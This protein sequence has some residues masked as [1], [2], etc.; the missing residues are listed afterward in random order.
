MAE[1][2]KII[3]YTKFLEK[4][5]EV[6]AYTPNVDI[7]AYS[8]NPEAS[9]SSLINISAP[10]L[11][12]CCVNGKC[13]DDYTQ[14]QCEELNGKFSINWE[15]TDSPLPSWKQIQ[16]KCPRAG[17]HNFICGEETQS[18]GTKTWYRALNCEGDG[19]T[20]TLLYT[21]DSAI[22]DAIE[23]IP[24]SDRFMLKADRGILTNS[25]N[26]L[27]QPEAKI[28]N[29]YFRNPVKVTDP[30][31]ESSS[32]FKIVQV[33]TQDI[34]ASCAALPLH[35]CC[36]ES[37]GS[38]SNSETFSKE[39]CEGRGGFWHEGENCM[40]SY[41]SQF[42]A[43]SGGFRPKW[44]GKAKPKWFPRS[45]PWPPDYF[46]PPSP[47]KKSYNPKIITPPGQLLSWPLKMNGED[48]GVESSPPMLFWTSFDASGEDYASS[49]HPDWPNG[50]PRPMREGKVNYCAHFSPYMMG[51]GG[52]N[53]YGNASPFH[54]H[55]PMSYG[56][57]YPLALDKFHMQGTSWG[58]E[59][60]KQDE[61]VLPLQFPLNSALNLPD[62]DVVAAAD[63]KVVY[64]HDG[65][66][67]RCNGNNYNVAGQCGDPTLY[68]NYIIID[69]GVKA[70]HVPE[71]GKD[72]GRVFRYTLYAHLKKDSIKRVDSI[73]FSSPWPAWK[74]GDKV[75]RGDKIGKIG[76]SGRSTYP[77]LHFEVGLELT[78]S[79]PGYEHSSG[80]KPYTTQKYLTNH[81]DPF[82][83]AEAWPKQGTADAGGNL[84][85]SMAYAD[86]VFGKINTVGYWAQQGFVM[87]ADLDYDFDSVPEDRCSL[88]YNQCS[89][90]QGPL[91]D[92]FF[93]PR[94]YWPYFMVDEDEDGVQEDL[95]GTI[96]TFTNSINDEEAYLN[97]HMEIIYPTESVGETQG[98]F[99]GSNPHWTDSTTN[100][101][102]T[103]GIPGFADG[104][105][106]DDSGAGDGIPDP[107]PFLCPIFYVNNNPKV[108][109]TNTIDDPKTIWCE[110]TDPFDDL[111]EPGANN[112]IE[113][114]NT[115]YTIAE[116]DREANSIMLNENLKS[117]SFSGTEIKIPDK[118][119]EEEIPFSSVSNFVGY[120]A[121][122]P[123]N[124]E[125][126]YFFVHEEFMNEVL[127]KLM[128]L[129]Q[130]GQNEFNITLD[131][132]RVL[133]NIYQEDNLSKKS[134]P[135]LKSLGGVAQVDK[136]E[137]C[138]DLPYFD[139]F[140]DYKK[141]GSE[142]TF[143][144]CPY[145]DTLIN[146]KRIEDVVWVAETDDGESKQLGSGN[147]LKIKE[148][149]AEIL[150]S[151]GSRTKVAVYPVVT[152]RE[153]IPHSEINS[154]EN[155]SSS[156][157]EH[158]D[159]G[160]TPSAGSPESENKILIGRHKSNKSAPTHDPI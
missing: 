110:T 159:S 6:F 26:Y 92:F 58:W 148:E 147:P 12:A 149:D 104:G 142:Y 22:S 123:N 33:V 17:Y 141:N 41:D 4:H 127:G 39:E 111:D 134:I 137:D 23:A 119:I 32:L 108:E 5:G 28:T 51:E 145:P 38:V 37:D 120:D 66:L 160:R 144:A 83:E 153:C 152:L 55:V 43:A 124:L 64:V 151:E 52:L 98:R 105:Y 62:V 155:I 42:V 84:V 21:T 40:T 73:A 36:T 130:G 18:A 11:S 85:R 90:L 65:E 10:L 157:P 20:E 131:D 29:P 94:P 99:Y 86:F 69:H 116:I 113:I 88:W 106:V 122:M 16:V 19:V 46:S 140:S 121:S 76:S 95:H 80:W 54:S 1:N 31:F 136:Q 107:Q 87:Q 9:K 132:G 75:S 70:G 158:S 53:W 77:Q 78:T 139:Y 13:Y 129:S 45:L 150:S 103:T 156:C 96:G 82:H 146:R 8:I 133:T 2:I 15:W 61:T 101:W 114:A 25:V 35:S 44:G 89:I 79:D 68:G 143:Y 93:R 56:S 125:P 109:V 34:C 72:K 71:P 117:D 14:E 63:G 57:P 81:V 128:H 118:V 115:T 100:V 47:K 30:S 102:S 126:V 49:W 97:G 3:G 50:F 112:Q 27:G 24:S 91:K 7:E 48:A 138:A 59:W 135:N 74:E 67:D 154:I 60:E